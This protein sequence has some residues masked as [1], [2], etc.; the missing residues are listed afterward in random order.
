MASTSIF[1]LV[2]ADWKG[3]KCGCLALYIRHVSMSVSLFLMA[4][5]STSLWWFPTQQEGTDTLTQGPIAAGRRKPL[6]HWWSKLEVGQRHKS[7]Y[8]SAG[9]VEFAGHLC[10]LPLYLEHHRTNHRAKAA[11]KDGASTMKLNCVTST[12]FWLFPPWRRTGN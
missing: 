5:N 1:L 11:A 8:S 9:S 2:S 4:P 12:L 3:R 6:Q 10:Q 7:D